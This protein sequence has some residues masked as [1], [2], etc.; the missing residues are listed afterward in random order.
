MAMISRRKIMTFTW[1]VLLIPLLILTISCHKDE[2]VVPPQPTNCTYPAGNRSFVWRVD[3][4]AWYPST[5]GGV[6][7]FSDS[8]AYLMGYIGEG[9]S[10]FR[11]FVGLH[12]NGTVWNNSINGADLEVAHF[13]NDVVGDDHFMV[14]VGYFS[15]SPSRPGLAEFDNQTKKWKG[16]QFQTNGELHA[17]W[18]DG[19]GYF[20]AVGDS[21]MVYIKDGYPAS[22][23]YHKAPTDFNF[24]RVTG[25]SKS[26]N[27]LLGYKSVGGT[28]YPQIWRYSGNSWLKLLDDLDTTGTV[29]RIPGDDN[30]IGDISVNR[31]SITDSLK[32]YVV[33]WESYL[34]EAKANSTN[35]KASN[36][37]AL[38]LPLRSLGRTGLDINLYSPDDCWIFG[39]R[40]NFYHWNG[41]S[42]QKIVIP[43]LPNDDM[44]FGDQRKMVK[45]KS[46]RMFLPTEVSSQVYVVVQG[47]PQ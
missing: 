36:L 41:S 6:W 35:Y 44:Q 29:I 45:T 46:G 5:L 42:F 2:P 13:S 22:W 17:V 11:I 1:I 39:T 4:V 38:G 24:Y 26:E 25:I 9:K 3:T 16:Y 10:P 31:C 47:V 28:T 20:I 15:I 40:Y 23:I 43:G 32:L 7:A 33:G 21:G 37:A 12:W 27:Y 34:F 8:D 18:T 19:K 14:S 30:T